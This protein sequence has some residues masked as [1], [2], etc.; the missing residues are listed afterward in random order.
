MPAKKA[1][2]VTKKAAKKSVAKKAAA[3]STGFD[4]FS[5]DFDLV[6]QTQESLI[7]LTAQ[8]KNKAITLEKHNTFDQPYLP[9]KHLGLQIGLQNKG[10]QSRRLYEII[11]P[12]GVGKTSLTM[13]IAGQGMDAGIPCVYIETEEKLMAKERIERCL[14][15]NP[16]RAAMKANRM[17]IAKAFELQQAWD[18]IQTNIIA[19]REKNKV[20]IPK[21]IPIFVVIDSFSKLMS[22]EQAQGRL[23]YGKYAENKKAY[24]EANEGTNFGHSKWS[25]AWC[26]E[27]PNWL[28]KNNVILWCIS[29]QNDKI[30]MSAMPGN[31]LMSPDVAAGFNKTKIGGRAL[32]Q[33][34]AMQFI[35]TRK[36]FHKVGTEQVGEKICLKVAKNSYGPGNNQIDYVLKTRHRTDT[37]EY[38]EPALDFDEGLA[39]LMAANSILGT[40]VSRKRF[41]C[42]AIGANALSAQDFCDLIHQNEDTVTRV[43]AIFNV[44]GYPRL[45]SLDNV[46]QEDLDASAE[47]LEEQQALEDELGDPADVYKDPTLD[48]GEGN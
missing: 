16:K 5:D 29:H 24:K 32:N 47:M 21:D 40:T 3:A 19:L 22:K 8:K 18:T 1:T 12:E 11:A 23:D 14:D 4:L 9:F 46:T 15:S 41:S 25:A 20:T 30:N 7:S 39:D 44:R 35:L 43:G 42:E 33:N 37:E 48:D 10:L 2:K 45:A 13:T 36:G 34:A 17:V 28:N 6:Q 31:S 26:R 38:Q 27:L